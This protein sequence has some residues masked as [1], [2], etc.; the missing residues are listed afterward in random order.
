M[1]IN[2]NN[3]SIT[4]YADLHSAD[5]HDANLHGAWLHGANLSGANLSGA[6][7]SGADLYGAKEIPGYVQDMLSILPAGEIT[8]WKTC[9]DNMLVKLRIPA[10]ARRSNA[11]GRKCRAEYADILDIIGASEACG[12]YDPQTIYRIGERITPD[13]YD[14]DWTV[15]CGH[16]IHFFITRSEAENYG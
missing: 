15:E 13:S 12:I 5:L 1:E 16:G 9:A 6:N 4:P 3:Y 8:G 11:T 7:L 14:D 2:G 10:E